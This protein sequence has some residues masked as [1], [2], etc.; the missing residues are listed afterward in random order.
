MSRP[1]GSISFVV[2]ETTPPGTSGDDMAS[3][4]TVPLEVFLHGLDAGDVLDFRQHPLRHVERDDFG[5]RLADDLVGGIGRFAFAAEDER[6]EAVRITEADRGLCPTLVL[7]S[8][9]WLR[10]AI[11]RSSIV[12]SARVEGCSFTSPPHSSP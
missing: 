6:R 1:A 2:C 11:L 10:Q 8:I 9:C 5:E 7:M 4:V 12:S 3:V